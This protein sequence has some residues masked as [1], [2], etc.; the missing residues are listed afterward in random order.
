MTCLLLLPKH[1]SAMTAIMR[2]KASCS[3]LPNSLHRPVCS[4]ASA[5]L[6]EASEYETEC[7]MSKDAGLQ[8]TKQG[9]ADCRGTMQHQSRPA[10][11]RHQDQPVWHGHDN[12]S[13]VKR[14]LSNDATNYNLAVKVK[15]CQTTGSDKSNRRTKAQYLLPC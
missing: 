14:L 10:C 12:M 9:C 2:P 1:F 11:M 4:K 3:G 5:M 15:S 6:A 7:A 13:L 8:L